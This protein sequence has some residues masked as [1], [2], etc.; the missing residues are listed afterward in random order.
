MAVEY[1]KIVDER[2]AGADVSRFV[3]TVKANATER[4]PI[5]ARLVRQL[6]SQIRYTGVEFGDICF[7]L[8]RLHSGA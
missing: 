5:I 7:R 8:M 3:E 4:S 6:H 1:N 2:I